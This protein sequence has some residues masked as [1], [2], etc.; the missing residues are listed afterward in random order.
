MEI[1]RQSLPRTR[2]TQ[3]GH[4]NHEKKL[5]IAIQPTIGFLSIG[6]FNCTANLCKI[7]DNF[8]I[9]TPYLYWYHEP[10]RHLNILSLFNFICKKL[11]PGNVRKSD[12]KHGLI[13]AVNSRTMSEVSCLVFFNHLCDAAIGQDVACV[14]QSVEHLRSLLNLRYLK[15]LKLHSKFKTNLN[16]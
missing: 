2:D 15:S 3:T 1:K 13:F 10:K 8:F 14:N 9:L 16:L 11:T 7:S 6:C 5:G 12:G 4:S